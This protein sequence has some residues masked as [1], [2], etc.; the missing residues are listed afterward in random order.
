M[1]KVENEWRIM[2]IEEGVIR[3]EIQWLFCYLFTIIPSLKKK[4]MLSVFIR[5]FLGKYI[6]LRNV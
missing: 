4:L 3:R 2:D 6:I 1:N 5:Q